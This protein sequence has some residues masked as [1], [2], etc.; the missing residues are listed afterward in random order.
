MEKLTKKTIAV[1]IAA[2][3]TVVALIG[4]VTGVVVSEYGGT[5]IVTFVTNGGTELEPLTL[6]RGRKYTLP[7]TEKDGLVFADWYYDENFDSVCKREIT[8]KKDLILYARFGAILTF[9]VGGGTDLEPRMY[10]EGEELGALPATY[11][12]GFSFGGWFYDSQYDKV[13]GRKDSISGALTVYAKF[14]EKTDTLKKL[15]SVKGVSVSPAVEVKATD[16]VLHNENVS[17]Y[18]SLKSASG[19]EIEIICAPSEYDKFVIQPARDL[20]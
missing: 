19:E 9:D 5:I 20:I 11:K 2:A 8:A 12:N 6:K 15:T 10:F 18:I 7:T 17:E 1:I 13:V 16:V 3:I 14:S 4:A